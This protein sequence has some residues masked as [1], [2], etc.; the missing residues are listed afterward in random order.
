MIL[1]LIVGRILLPYILI[2]STAEAISLWKPHYLQ[3]SGFNKGPPVVSVTENTPKIPPLGLTGESLL[4]YF[5]RN[6]GPVNI[7]NEESSKP[8][9]INRLYESLAQ[10]LK[11]EKQ[12]GDA[13]SS[14]SCIP[15]DSIVAKLTKDVNI[16][17][18]VH[19]HNDYWR[20]LPLLE[21]LLYGVTSVEADVWLYRNSTALAVGHNLGYLNTAQHDLRT[22][23]LDPLV[24]ILDQ[25][26]CHMDTESP[27]YG[28]F[29]DDPAQQLLLY[30]DFKPAERRRTFIVLLEYLR[31]LIERGYLSYYD[32]ETKT[33]TTGP[34]TVILT[35]NYPPDSEISFPN[36]RRYTFLDA[37]L[38]KLA[39]KHGLYTASAVSIVASASMEQLLDYCNIMG[40][41]DTAFN[42]KH[43]TDLPWKEIECIKQHVSKAH[44]FGLQTRIWGVPQ[45]PVHGRN[46]LWKKLLDVGVDY[47][48]VDDLRAVKNF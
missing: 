10:Y 36:N 8:V 40:A 48:N 14:E 27:L 2:L 20:K 38:H 19:S 34:I 37:P 44:E 46:I 11:L 47:L 22:L 23:Y 21:A 12:N 18:N 39:S 5:E 16:L 43:A 26:N 6:L 33:L 35:G 24:Q 1:K 3:F 17:G 25:V 32:F 29:Y 9:R 13:P 41:S 4:C 42:P 30:I 15:E 45:W 7:P 31:P 28:P